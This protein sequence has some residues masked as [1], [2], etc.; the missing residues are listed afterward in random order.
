V[1][2]R[3]SAPD[4]LKALGEA[5][6]GQW[7]RVLTGALALVGG[8]HLLQLAALIARFGEWPNYVRLYDWPGAVAHILR[9]TPSL[10][11]VLGI[12]R[13]EWLVEVGYMNYDFGLGISEWSLSVQPAR[14][15]AL[16][17]FGALLAAHLAM[18]GRLK[19]T[20]C[21]L[22]AADRA[23]GTM[24]GSLVAV[25]STTMSWVVCCAT[26]SWVVGLS[27]LGLGVSAA[28][29]IEPLGP[30]LVTL[31]FGML[32]NQLVVLAR[33]VA[34]AARPIEHEGEEV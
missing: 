13:E 9:S 22:R 27:M 20:G 10:S 12:I 14:V 4:W 31:G 8:Y 23:V 18:L 29:A 19:R 7:R 24:A 17:A 3:Y 1:S 28:L 34:T 26:P 25:T 30:W 6:R 33:R 5:V 11:D 32:G 16:M 15:L 2:T 21:R